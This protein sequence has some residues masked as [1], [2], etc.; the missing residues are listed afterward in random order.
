MLE[1]AGD[2]DN[3]RTRFEVGSVRAALTRDLPSHQAGGGGVTSSSRVTLQCHSTE[4]TFLAEFQ[5]TLCFGCKD[6][7]L[8]I[9]FQ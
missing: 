5:E 9:W 8:Y 1:V 3:F 7:K 2:M 4:G 6:L